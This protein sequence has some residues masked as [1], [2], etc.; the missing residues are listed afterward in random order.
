LRR[1]RVGPV[2]LG[3]LPEGAHRELT[4][5]ELATLKTHAR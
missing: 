4:E 2:A 1:L 5:E 3:D